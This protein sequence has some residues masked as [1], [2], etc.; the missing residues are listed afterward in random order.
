MKQKVVGRFAPSPTGPLHMG[1]LIAAVGSYLL[2]RRTGG[3]WLLRIEDLDT[4]RVVPG[5]ADDM[6]RTLEA[7]GFE[8]DGEVV[9]QSRRLDAYKAALDCLIEKG[10]AYP[11]G[12]SRAEIALIASAPHDAEGVIYPGLCREGLPAEKSERAVRVK[13]YDEMISL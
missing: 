3:Q 4:P 12:C 5:M 2:A 1:S 10:I 13:V 8:W 7:L 11:C 6:L 9:Y